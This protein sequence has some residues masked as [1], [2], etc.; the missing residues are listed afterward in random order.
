MTLQDHILECVAGGLPLDMILKLD[1]ESFDAMYEGH[2]RNKARAA[3]EG[4]WNIAVATNGKQKDIKDWLKPY[5]RLLDPNAG[6][7][8]ADQLEADLGKGGI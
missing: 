1:L 3:I 7:R 6:M 4:V 8:S 5:Y 2:L